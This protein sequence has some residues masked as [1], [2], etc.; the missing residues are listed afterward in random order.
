MTW[1]VQNRQNFDW[2]SSGSRNIVFWNFKIFTL[3]F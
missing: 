1:G 2:D 3:W